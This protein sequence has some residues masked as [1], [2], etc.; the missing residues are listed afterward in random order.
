MTIDY[1]ILGRKLEKLYPYLAKELL[2]IPDLDDLELI[3]CLYTEYCS[4]QAKPQ[5]KGQQTNL[6][7]IFIAS[8]IKLY[9][10]DALEFRKNMKNGLRQKLSDT[11]HC[12][13]TLISDNFTTVRNY[14]SIYPDFSNEVAYIYHELK[15]YAYGRDKT[16]REELSCP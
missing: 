8:I 2:T 4:I 1:S 13:P 6:R 5:S 15:M 10:P 12:H 7:L 3:D 16:G 9:D 14:L 11:L